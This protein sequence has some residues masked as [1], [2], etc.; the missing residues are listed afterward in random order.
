MHDELNEETKLIY[1]HLGPFAV[2]NPENPQ[3]F[4]GAGIGVTPLVSMFEVIVKDSNAQ[5]IQV[6]GDVNIHHSLHI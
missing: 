3:L 5:F 4:I 1:Q 2:A 6:T